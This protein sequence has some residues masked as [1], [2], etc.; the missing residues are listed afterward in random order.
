M[1]S[2]FEADRSDVDD[3]L[4]AYALDAVDPEERAMV[5]RHLA[6]DPAARAEVDEMRET[7]AA[8]ASLPSDDEGAPAGLW[9]R[10]ADAIGSPDASETTT[11]SESATP[12]APPPTNVVPLTRAA[13]SF[14]ARIVVP[15]VAA[16][17][18]VIVVLGVQVA[19]R[20]P[21][22]A[23]DLAAAY[24][25]AV[26][27]G[28]ATVRL[29]AAGQGTVAAEIAL[30]A[31]G[32]GYLRNEHLAALPDGKTYQL[33]ALETRGSSQQAISAGVLGRVP[34]AVAFHVAGAP[35]GFA[36]TVENAPGV[37]ASQQSPVAVGKVSA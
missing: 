2:R 12:A 11:A 1:S 16:A 26:A 7:A 10:I 28:A 6:D 30:Q 21:S 37:V 22:R 19:T 34:S 35:S 13:R 24:N 25:H 14:S 3:I 29:Q 23:G 9:S 15:L 5:E 17:A 4:G 20:T 8:L 33:W 31:D 32:T 27:G 36:I 18:V